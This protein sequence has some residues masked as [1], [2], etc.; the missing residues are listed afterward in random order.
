MVAVTMIG[1]RRS[2]TLVLT[3]NVP[4]CVCVFVGAEHVPMPG[5]GE[6]RGALGGRA[7]APTYHDRVIGRCCIQ[8]IGINKCRN[9]TAEGI[10]QLR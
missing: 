3:L 5:A 6:N 7:I 4:L 8:R 1:A 10:L 9:N 2:L